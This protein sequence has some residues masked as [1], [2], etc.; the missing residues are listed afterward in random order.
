MIHD[1]LQRG[2]ASGL[3]AGLAYGLYMVL[4]GN[5]LSGYVDAVAAGPDGHA[6]EG[7]GHVVSETMTAAVSATSGVLWGIL[8]GGVFAIAFYFLEPALPGR[9]DVKAYVLAGAGFLS[10]SV[11]PWLVFPPAAPGAV[12]RYGIDTRIAVYLGLVVVGVGL[13]A[14][15]I[16][17]YK[18]FARRHLG[19]GIL[20]GA[21]PILVVAVVLTTLAPTVVTHP[22]LPADLV[23]A[24]RGLVILTQ[25]ALWALIAGTFTRLRRRADRDRSTRPT[26]EALSDI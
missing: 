13:S 26:G 14:L 11:T 9:G 19:L 12:Q 8:L 25:A 5:P 17:A 3:V 7:A 23:A 18:R 6:S 4:V 16:G 20:A 10:V 1:Y 15:A 22:D 2:V 24:Y 21:A